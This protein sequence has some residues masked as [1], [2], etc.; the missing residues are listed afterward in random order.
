MRGEL[1]S[2]TDCYI[3][4]QS[5]SDHSS[6]SF[7]FWLVAQPWVTE[8]PSPLSG[9]DSHSAGFLSPT[10]TAN[11]PGR[12]W[13]LVIPLFDVHLLPVGVRIS[14][15]HGIQPRP[16]VKV[17]FRYLRPDAPVSLF[18]RLFTQVHLFID[19]SVESQY[20]TYIYL[21]YLY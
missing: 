9:A 10:G 8:G 6:T 12:L 11:D 18:F 14:H 15:H 3:L 2:G 16:Q 5:S 19:G 20:V 7:V 1:E 21:N 17:I 4:T 13:H